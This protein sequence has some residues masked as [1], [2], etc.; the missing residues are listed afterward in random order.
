LDPALSDAGIATT[1]WIRMLYQQIE[2]CN[3]LE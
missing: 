3:S 2:L 1:P